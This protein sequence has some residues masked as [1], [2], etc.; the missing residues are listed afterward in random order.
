MR[1]HCFLAAFAG[2]L[3]GLAM[4]AAGL[5]MFWHGVLTVA[6]GLFALWFGLHVLFSRVG[7]LPFG[8]GA[9]PWPDWASLDFASLVL[10]MIAAVMLFRLHT[11]IIATLLVSAA[12][13]AAW[14]LLG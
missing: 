9:V 6:V 5:D 14:Q 2:T 10:L 12:L 3:G 4:M 8:L 7:S 1:M 11:G 13:G